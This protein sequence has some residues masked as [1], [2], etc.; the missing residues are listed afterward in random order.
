MGGKG[1]GEPPVGAEA[2]C[3]QGRGWWGEGEGM[4]GR[5]MRGRGGQ[6]AVLFVICGN[7]GRAIKVFTQTP[8]AGGED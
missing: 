7:L 6:A 1:G 5:R 3:P 4:E 8:R 2:G